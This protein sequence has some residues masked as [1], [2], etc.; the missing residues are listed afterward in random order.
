MQPIPRD[1][2]VR[3]WVK[4]APVVIGS[5]NSIQDTRSGRQKKS[6]G[7]GVEEYETQYA[8]PCASSQEVL[9]GEHNE[10]GDGHLI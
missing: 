7:G 8:D 10:P 1:S 6:Q 3:I 4:R 9:P 2:R 5:G